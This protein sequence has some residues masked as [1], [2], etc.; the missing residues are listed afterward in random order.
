MGFVYLY[1]GL[2][3]LLPLHAVYALLMASHGISTSQLSLLF[4]LWTVTT[5]LCEI[6]SGA[7]ADR[8][9][10]HR[11]LA[12]AALAQCT[13]FALWIALPSLSSFAAGFVLWGLSSA[14][15]SGTLQSLIY[16]GLASDG[17]S[18]EYTRVSSR[19]ATVQACSIAVSS[20]VASPVVLLG[21]YS[22]AGWI[23]VLL[24]LLAVPTALSLGRGRQRVPATDAPATDGTGTDDVPTEGWL[25]LLRAGLAEARHTPQVRS[26]L[27]MIS[28]LA[29][30]SVVD[31]YLPVLAKEGGAPSAVIPLLLLLPWGAMALGS[32]MGW[33]LS[34]AGNRALA[35][36]LIVG[37]SALALG[38][39]SRH[40]GGFL[41]IAV[42][43]WIL[44][45]IQVVMGARL[46][47]AITGPARATVS[48]VAGLGAQ[49]VALMIFLGSSVSARWASASVLVAATSIPVFLTAMLL[50][51]APR[52]LPPPVAPSAK[53][54]V[55]DIQP[56]AVSGP[57]LQAD[58]G[59]DRSA[60][61][62]EGDT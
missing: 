26:C 62:K 30:V 34:G 50:L 41:G 12:C 18:D 4:A 36:L 37:G 15:T 61:T 22:A 43:Y 27:L 11:V 16:D 40:P 54:D 57:T 39:L 38:A 21:G 3:E 31:E 58:T 6:P 14:L 59:E 42:F 20:V 56:V 17:R 35:G 8:F 45:M 60:S 28:V 5:F 29:G 1:T 55:D 2:T 53:D 51:L 7:V 23:S 52:R 44:R 10:R 25:F 19:M 24:T 47:H 49:S 9:P 33:R 48:S 46:Q 13:G 32:F